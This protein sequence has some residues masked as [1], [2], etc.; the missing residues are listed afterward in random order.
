LVITEP[1]ESKAY[2]P[3]SPILDTVPLLPGTE[4]GRVV[5]WLIDRGLGSGE[6]T[7]DPQLTEL[8]EY[9]FGD[10]AHQASSARLGAAIDRALEAARPH[11]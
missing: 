4:A 8:A 7:R 5:D 11:S 6:G 1:E 3:P 9:Y 10:T 2:R